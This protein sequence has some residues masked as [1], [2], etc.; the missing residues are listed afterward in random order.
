MDP[1]SVSFLLH[2]I[3]C[4]VL[5]NAKKYLNIQSAIVTHSMMQHFHIARFNN[6]GDLSEQNLLSLPGNCKLEKD[7]ILQLAFLVLA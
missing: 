1:I 5:R 2:K 4:M 7:L 3:E 6:T